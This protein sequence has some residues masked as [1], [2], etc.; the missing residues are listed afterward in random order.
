M[1]FP[2]NAIVELKYQYRVNDQVCMNVTHWNP[3]G[4]STGFAVQDMVAGFLSLALGNGNGT[5]IGEAGKLQSV[6]AQYFRVSAQMIFPVRWA[7]QATDVNFQG[8]I[9][10]VVPAQNLA[11]TLTKRGDLGDR[12]NLGSLHVGGIPINRFQEGKVIAAALTDAAGLVTWLTTDRGDGVSP[13]D[14]VPVIL[15]KTPIPNTDP[16]RYQISGSSPITSVS[17]Q[18]TARVMRRRTLRVGI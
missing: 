8:T 5:F 13:V 6:N 7:V 14:Y 15:N 1:S 18:D 2:A 17:V 9:D 12:H 3:Q 16:V 11:I 4:D 10:Q